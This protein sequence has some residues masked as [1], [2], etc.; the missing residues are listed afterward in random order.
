[1]TTQGKIQPGLLGRINEWRVLRTIQRHGPLSRAELARAT[2][3]TAPTASKAVEALVR[4]GWLIETDDPDIRRGRPAK[5]LCLPGA[6]AQVLGLVVDWPQCRLVVGGLDGEL[7]NERYF[8]TPATYAELLEVTQTW[9]RERMA[10]PGVRTYGLCVALPGLIDYTEQRCLLSPNVHI[11]DNQTPARDL[12][13]QLGLE[14]V[15]IHEGHALC[16]AERQGGGAQSLDDFA[17]MDLSTGVGLPVVV[18]GQHFT[19]HRGLAGE[20]GHITVNPNGRRCGCGNI[21]CLE[22][23]ISDPALQ[24]ALGAATLEE[25][26]ARYNAGETETIDARLDY[27]AIGIAAAIHLYNPSTLFLNSRLLR[28]CPTLLPK[29]R[30]QLA[31]RTLR[32][33]LEDCQI[34]LAQGNKSQGVIVGVIEHLT[35]ARLPTSLQELH[36]LAPELAD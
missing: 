5:K 18:R 6:E 34:L 9:A 24:Q 8:S 3:I 29:L 32:P 30:K 20:L 21:G 19:G 26:V 16:L 1:M 36:R 31:V 23:E 7:R 15:V 2:A 14:C 28:D 10:L 4:E 35:N 12:A 22:T 25:T 13:A 11:T 27:M 33:A 17:L